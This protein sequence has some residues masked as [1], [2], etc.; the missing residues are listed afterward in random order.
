MN[1]EQIIL[2]FPNSTTVDI[3]GDPVVI[4]QIVQRL[5]GLVISFEHTTSFGFDAKQEDEK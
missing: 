2:R 5:D 4:K 1:T 3:A